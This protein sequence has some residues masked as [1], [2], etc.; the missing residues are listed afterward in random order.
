M[1]RYVILLLLTGTVWA[2][3][4][5][6]KLVLKDG[7]EYQGKF[8]RTEKSFVYFNQFKSKN[9]WLARSISLQ[10]VQ[11]IQLKDGENLKLTL[12]KFEVYE[13]KKNK[14]DKRDKYFAVLLTCS[15]IVVAMIYI[16][17]PFEGLGQSPGPIFTPPDA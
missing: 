6:D 17:N 13:A 4:D 2:Q 3:T 14:Y 5:L 15:V 12:E 11:T 16:I 1:R 9:E 10:D 7:T 8:L